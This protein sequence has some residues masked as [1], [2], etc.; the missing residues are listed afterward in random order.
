MANFFYA[1]EG[2]QHGPVTENELEQMVLTGA[3]GSDVYVWADGMEEWQPWAAVKTPLTHGTGNLSLATVPG[4]G[5]VPQV[6]CSVCNHQYPSDEV[7]RHRSNIVCSICKDQYFAALDRA[8][9]AVQVSEPASVIRRLVARFVD[10]IVNLVLWFIG[11]L[12]LGLLMRTGA[13]GA[14]VIVVVLYQIVLVSIFF[15]L[16]A[17]LVAKYGHTPGKMVCRIKVLRQDGSRLSFLRAFG[18]HF[19][20]IASIF[21]LGVAYAVGLFNGR[22]Q[23]LH[24]LA[25][26]S[27]VVYDPN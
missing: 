20:D 14:K 19:L 10:G 13:P 12:L 6:T 25:T 24:D 17:L 9:K 23:T 8:A 7:T 2:Q 22:R 15:L 11:L 3:L 4:S 21:T 26:D 1:I 18:R 16:P 27:V 5:G